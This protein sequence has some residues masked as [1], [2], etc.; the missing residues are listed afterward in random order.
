MLVDTFGK[1][2]DDGAV[3]LPIVAAGFLYAASTGPI[4]VMLLM[5]GRSS[6][7]MMNNLIAL[8][9]NI[10]LNLVLIPSMGLRG[11]AIAWT[12]SIV[13]TNLLPTLEVRHTMGYHPYGRAWFRAVAISAA[14]VAIP[15]L[16]ARE[17][18]GADRGPG[19]RSA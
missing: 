15:E 19:W 14:A 16:T 2:F 13:L 8:V 7:S 17:L 1:G 3:V 10:G 12:T 4:D 6:L 5:G 11:A 18:I 9:T